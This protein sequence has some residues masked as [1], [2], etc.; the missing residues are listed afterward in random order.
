MPLGGY[1]L[2]M[3]IF[4]RLPLLSGF[5]LGFSD[6]GDGLIEISLL[7]HWRN[8]LVH[9]AAWDV[10]GYFYPHADTLGYNDG[11]FLYGLDFALWRTVAD[12]FLADTLNLLTFKTIGFV[13][14]Y[15]LA[16]RVLRWRPGEG[17]LLALLFTI[18][19]GLVVQVGHAQVESVALLPV[20]IMLAIAGVSAARAGR[21]VAAG[22][23]AVGLAALMGAWLLT[24]YYMS[25]FTLF[26]GAIYVLAWGWAAGVR[27]P[28]A[29]GRIVRVHAVPL[30]AGGVAFMVFVVPFLRVYL[31]KLGETGGQPFGVTMGYLVTPLIDHINVGPDNIVWGWLFRGLMAIVHHFLPGDAGLPDRVIGGEHSTGLPPILFGLAVAALWIMVRRKRVA[32]PW[33]ALALTIVIAWL[34]TIQLGPVSPW[35][36]VT[37]IVPG[38]RGLRVVSRF[39]LLLVLPVLLV[40]IGIW[41]LRVRAF[42]AS[43]H[44]ATRAVLALL[45][46]E[47][48]N[49]APTAG[50][51][52]SA[53]LRALSAIP[54]PPPQCASFAA[55]STRKAEPVYRDAEHDALCPHNVDAMLL[56]QLWRIPTINGF[57]TFNPP[58]WAFA[59]PSAPDYR[60]RVRAYVA[61]HRLTGVC[62]LD[63]RATAPWQPI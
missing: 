3:V 51:S 54:P 53:Q 36:I 42:S 28:A 9:G 13:A 25:W 6:R 38:A 30:I 24:T 31:P 10:T 16:V 57:A 4:F 23:W 34:L 18:A 12:P 11:Y 39:Q 49:L 17:A 58:D 46:V 26:F 37:F 62:L 63:M 52:R 21:S 19:N 40:T 20:A 55:G 47:Q 44:W 27:Y 60:A 22:G 61:R 59:A 1:L 41:R 15:A 7:E 2:A 48:I 33:R 35:R 29:I 50:I 45:I 56:A 14:S 32:A 43:R 8:V 5:D